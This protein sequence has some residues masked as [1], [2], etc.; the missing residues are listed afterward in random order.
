[1][2]AV[3]D[4]DAPAFPSAANSFG[5]VPAGA[6]RFPSVIVASMDDPYGSLEY[7]KSCAQKWHSRLVS[8]GAS[9][10]INA[11]SKLGEWPQGKALLNDFVRSLGLTERLDLKS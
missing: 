5:E 7:V 10:H 9:G 2:V 1:L 8:I 3:P 4:P 6:L 11:S